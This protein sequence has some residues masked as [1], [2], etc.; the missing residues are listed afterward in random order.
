MRLRTTSPSV[1]TRRLPLMLLLGV[2]AGCDGGPPPA[3]PEVRP[4]FRR[5]PMGLGASVTQSA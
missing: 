1:L 4:G 3:P 5:I 2:I